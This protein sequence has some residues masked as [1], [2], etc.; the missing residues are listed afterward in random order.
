MKKVL[1]L[2]TSTGE[3]H[4]QAANSLK[5]TLERNGFEVY[6]EDFLKNNSKVLSTT[7]IGGYDF[8]AVNFPKIYGLTYKLTDNFLSILGL[9]ISYTFTIK[10]IKKLVNDINPDFIISTHPF[11]IPL[12]GKLKRSNIN[13]PTM[14]I[15]TDFKAH[16]SYIDKNIDY[17]IT[18]SE[19]T[20]DELVKQGICKNKI[21]TYGIPVK[22]EFYTSFPELLT[23]K[24]EDY[25]NILLMGG[26][27]GLNNIK[28]VLKELLNNT[29]KLRIT[30]ICG[31]NKKLKESLLSE[32]KNKIK[33]KKL[34]ILGFCNDIPSIMEFSDLLI[35]KPGGL[36]VTEA[37]VKNLPLIIPFAIPGQE[38]YNC[39]F[40]QKNNYAIKVD[41]L[42]E[43]NFI[44]DNLIDNRDNLN[45]L[46]N[47]IKFIANNYSKQKIVDLINSE[48]NRVD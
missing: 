8:F 27:M 32:Y 45:N 37:F 3:G 36:T 30:V 47:N 46:K 15:V 31:N 21:F 35:S 48:I 33:N 16:Y 4:N 23:T 34:H 40:L 19:Y 10:K 18:G 13:I 2:S 1:I 7:F 41:S 43:L 26:S 28:Y 14:S 20:K 11:A 17:Y 6:I 42:I 44:L 25:F 38:I 24:D 22:D 12:L 29:H 5:S 39:D 9:N